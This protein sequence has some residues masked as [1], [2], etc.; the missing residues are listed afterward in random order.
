MT[1]DPDWVTYAIFGTRQP[2]GRRRPPMPIRD[3]AR[4][5]NL[6]LQWL[7]KEAVAD[8]SRL[9]EPLPPNGVED[10]F[11]LSFRAFA[12]LG[13]A[14]PGLKVVFTPGRLTV[15]Y[16]GRAAVQGLF[17][18]ADATFTPFGDGVRVPVA[19]PDDC[20]R[21]GGWTTCTVVAPRR[22]IYVALRFWKEEPSATRTGGG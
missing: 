6:R 14:P 16:P 7:A 11:T 8:L 4:I 20:R 3:F 17:A 22:F 9:V 1:I 12:Q 5:R 13:D 10:R 15:T 2:E 18:T 21:S 19:L